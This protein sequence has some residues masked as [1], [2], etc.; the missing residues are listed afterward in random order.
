MGSISQFSFILKKRIS[1]VGPD[2]SFAVKQLASSYQAP[3]TR[4]HRKLRKGLHK[5]GVLSLYTSSKQEPESPWMI[6]TVLSERSLAPFNLQR[7]LRSSAFSLQHIYAVYRLSNRTSKIMAQ[8]L[9]QKILV[10]TGG[11]KPP[12]SGPLQIPL[13]FHKGFRGTIRA[14]LRQAVISREEYLIP[15]LHPPP[16]NVVSADHLSL[17]KL[18]GN[19]HKIMEEFDWGRIRAVDIA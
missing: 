11:A 16:C 4:L 5:P 8:S 9:L 12:K 13:L 10:F 19:H 2:Y 18:V 1:K 17:G 7:M 14:W 3:G 6:L 15:F